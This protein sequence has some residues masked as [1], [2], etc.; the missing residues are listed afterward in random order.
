[1]INK[2]FAASRMSF[3]LCGLTAVLLVGFLPALKRGQPPEQEP[4]GRTL[5]FRSHREAATGRLQI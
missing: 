4:F 1:M 3:T 2:I 5:R